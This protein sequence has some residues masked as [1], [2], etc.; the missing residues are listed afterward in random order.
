M[1]VSHLALVGLMG[2]GKSTI[3]RRCARV[4]DA[5]YIDT[6]ELV[7]AQSEMTI[8]DI[9]A[10][11]GESEFRAREVVAVHDA[12]LA[13]QLSVISCGG[14][15]VLDERNRSA[16]RQ[17]CVVVWLDAEISVLAE[18]VSRSKHRPLLMEGDSFVILERLAATRAT[19]YEGA[20]HV[21]IDTSKLDH[22]AATAAVIDAFVQ[23]DQVGGERT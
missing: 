1:A 12:T 20:A 22:E 13:P 7:E 18:R 23:F 15:V 14:G 10:T 11:F 5:Q 4:L 8:A 16:L 9:F 3:G 6:D 19:A 17:R 21:R 2:T